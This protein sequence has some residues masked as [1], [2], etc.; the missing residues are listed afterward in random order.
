MKLCHV[1]IKMFADSPAKGTTGECASASCSSSPS[2]SDD[3]PKC[4]LQRAHSNSILATVPSGE[5]LIDKG[6][7]QVKWNVYLAFNEIHQ[8]C[9]I[10]E[11]LQQSQFDFIWMQNNFNCKTG[12]YRF[13]VFLR[14]WWYNWG[15][16]L[17]FRTLRITYKWE[18]IYKFFQASPYNRQWRNYVQIF[19]LMNVKMNEVSYC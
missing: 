2:L 1:N 10:F 9:K 15:K 6:D 4:P 5:S 18:G 3:S 19:F 17:V 11:Y 13:S 7:L 16:H 8:N 12:N 14:I